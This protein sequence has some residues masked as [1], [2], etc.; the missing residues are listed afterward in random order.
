MLIVIPC[1]NEAAHLP[2]LLT[3]LSAASLPSRI[4]VADG[5]SSDGSQ[6]IVNEA[7][8]TDARITLLDNPARIQSAGVNLAVRT[9]GESE[10]FFVRIDAHA[11]YPANFLSQLAQAQQ[12]HGADSITI[13][14]HAAAEPG[15]CFQTAAAAAQNSVLG[16]GGSPHRKGGARRFVD[17]GHHALFK[18]EAFR[19]VGGYDESFSH[20]EDAELD[21]RL[22]QAGKSILLA[23]DIMIDYYPRKTARALALQYFRFGKGRAR[24][25][26]KHR[27]APKPRQLAPMMIAPALVAALVLG[28]IWPI[29]ALPTLLWLGLCLSYGAVLGLKA[30]NLCACGAG[31]AAAISHLA[32]S[33]G[34]L[35]QLAG[36]RRAQDA[37]TWANSSA[38]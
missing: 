30:R 29:F 20:N 15:Q 19:A 25:M 5:G 9:Y 26:Q 33:L 35:A 24:T 3:R 13:A 21:L 14:M 18:T 8:K 6:A 1:L 34:A 38:G 7:A 12:E 10:D 32:W 31:I 16:A 23:A 4:V 2:T 22:R 28:P 36:G 17:H 11:G 37:Q 27:I